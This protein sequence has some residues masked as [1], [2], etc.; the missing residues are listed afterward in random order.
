MLSEIHEASAESAWWSGS[1]PCCVQQEGRDWPVPTEGIF[2]YGCR[3]DFTAIWR[4]Q[5]KRFVDYLI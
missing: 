3:R 2:F 5:S 4:G 1:T